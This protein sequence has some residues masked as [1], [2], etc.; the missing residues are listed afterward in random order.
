MLTYRV[1]LCVLLSTFSI[2]LAYVVYFLRGELLTFLRIN[3][4][5]PRGGV[6]AR[7]V[8]CGSNFYSLISMSA[9]SML[10]DS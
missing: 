2:V 4:V 1:G 3:A 9:L 10:I 5:K 7:Y 8:S 6:R